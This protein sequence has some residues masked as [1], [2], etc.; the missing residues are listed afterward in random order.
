MY[1]TKIRVLSGAQK[2]VKSHQTLIYKYLRDK[3]SV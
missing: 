3:L 2:K 1:S